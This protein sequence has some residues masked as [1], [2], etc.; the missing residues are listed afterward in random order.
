VKHNPMAFFTDTQNR[1]CF[2]L[3]NFWVDLTN[4]NIGRYNWLTP[5][6]YN[7]MHN[8]M[9]GGFTYH[10]TTFTGD[11]SA[12]AA[13]DNFL[14][15]AIPRIMASQAYKDHGAII[16]WS[17]ETESTDDTS[18]TIP[19]V[20]ISPMAKGNAYA[21]TLPYSHASDLKTM[22]EVFGLAYQTNPIPA[23]ELDAQNDGYNY[24]D[25]RSAA[26]NDFSDFFQVGPKVMGSFGFMTLNASNNCSA[27]MI[28]V[29]GTNYVRTRDVLNNAL[30]ITQT[31][32]TGTPLATGTSN[33]VII[34]VTDSTGSSAYS[35]NWVFVA[36]AQGP[37]IL[38][39]PRSVTN[40]AGTSASFNVDASACTAISY[41]WYFGGNVL[42]GQ[43]NSTLNITSVGP[44][45]VGNYSVVVTSPGG[46]TNSVAATLTVMYQ[47]PQITGGQMMLGPGGFQ[48]TFS[49]PDG[50]TYQVLASDDP[51]APLSQWQVVGSGTFGSGDVVF[52]DPDAATHPN[53]FYRIT[54][55]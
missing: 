25:G 41:Q 5:D 43:T 19:F 3:T 28:D 50:Q 33:Q 55:P 45:N 47:A 7:E 27:A 37:A 12:V 54:S 14:S 32:A 39:E 1:N 35:T 8:A 52:S 29:T 20:I 4:N 44:T 40:N 24:V 26:V 10:G 51:A 21:S 46:S 15:I 48:L 30:T 6:L 13:G 34:T 18:T 23:S 38:G 17:D 49:G 31:P 42:T 16:I 11:Q 36:D 2:P 9:P 22:D 53:R